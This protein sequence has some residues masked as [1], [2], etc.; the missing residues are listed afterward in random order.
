[1]QDLEAQLDPLDHQ[2][3]QGLLVTRDRKAHLDHKVIKALQV[4]LA[5]W[6]QLEEQGSLAALVLLDQQVCLCIL[7]REKM[8]TQF[9]QA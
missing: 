8:K 4:Q 1:M 5:L 6:V 7:G 3:Q 9:N 2:D